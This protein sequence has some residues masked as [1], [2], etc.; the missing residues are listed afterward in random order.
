MGSQKNSTHFI[1][2][3]VTSFWTDIKKI[4]EMKVGIQKWI[5]E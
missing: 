4:E 3:I 5:K 1:I 2:D